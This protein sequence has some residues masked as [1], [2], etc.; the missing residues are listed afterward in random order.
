LMEGE[1]YSE[2][3][4]VAR[5]FHEKGKMACDVYGKIPF[6]LPNYRGEAANGKLST[7]QQYRFALCFENLYLDPWSRG[8]VTEKLFDCF[9]A[10]TVP[11]YWGAY[12]IERYV[13]KNCY[14]DF[15][16]FKSLEP[17]RDKLV[18][19]SQSEWEDRARS[20]QKYWQHEKPIYRWHWNRVYEDVVETAENIN[21]N[22]FRWREQWT[23][24]LPPDYPM[25]TASCCHKARFYLSCMLVRHHK[26]VSRGLW[27][28]AR[29]S[30]PIAR[31]KQN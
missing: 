1:L 30:Q 17:L 16:H 24:P 5:W 7:M 20:I 4:R 12:D 8:Y 18:A 23:Q 14:I 31:K 3:V 15:R 22:P 28:A 2:R 25:T 13:P 10:G 6:S 29:L 27:L 9:A 26:L 11:V 19:M 21:R